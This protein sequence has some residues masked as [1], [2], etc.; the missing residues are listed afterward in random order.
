MPKAI[1]FYEGKLKQAV[2][3]CFA[4]STFKNPL[5]LAVETSKNTPFAKGVEC[6][7]R[8]VRGVYLGAF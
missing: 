2:V 6:K 5:S 8:K 3:C 7:A 4:I 1:K